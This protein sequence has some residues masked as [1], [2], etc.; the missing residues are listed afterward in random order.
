MVLQT[1]IQQALQLVQGGTN[2]YCRK[3]GFPAATQAAIFFW[4]GRANQQPWELTAYCTV[5]SCFSMGSIGNY[6]DP[7][8]SLAV[9]NDVYQLRVTYS[10]VFIRNH[11]NLSITSMTI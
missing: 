7:F 5:Q 11:P 2:F 4:Q 1:L 9:C 6:G 3:V 8:A 10:A